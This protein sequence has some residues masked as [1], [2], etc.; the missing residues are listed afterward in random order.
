MKVD[1]RIDPPYRDR[2]LA[3]TIRRAA[4]ALDTQVQVPANASLTVRVTGD[5][6]VRKLN[7]QFLD[8]DAPTDVLAFPSGDPIEGELPY[9]GDIVLSLETAGRQAEAGGYD[10]AREI[11][12]LVIHGILHLLGHDHGDPEEKEAMWTAQSAVL[13][14]LGNPLSPP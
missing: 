12:L 4:G 7:R 1:V 6:E 13:E 10:L 5:E 8:V 3:E 2:A 14:A 11:E 9:L